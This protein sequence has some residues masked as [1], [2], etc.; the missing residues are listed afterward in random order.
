[1][2]TTP[3][4]ILILSANPTD[5][6]K[7]R[8]DE[9]AREILAGLQRSR[10]RDKFEMI[11]RWAVHP[12]DLRRALLDHSPQIVHFSGHG[13]GSLGLALENHT[14]QTQLV[15]TESL[16]RLFK[17]FKDKVEC[18]LLNACY[19]QEQ[20]EAIYQHI[21][22]V[23]GMNQAIGDRTAIEFAVGFYD[24]LGADRSYEEAYEFGCSAIDLEGIN[25]S[26]IPVLKSRL[27]ELNSRQQGQ[28][29][30]SRAIDKNR[31]VVLENPS[32]QVPLD[33]SFYIE[34]PPIEA[35]CYEIILSEGALIR[36]K[37]PKQMG[38][39]SLMTRIL[40]YAKR[41]GYQ[42]ANLNFQ[43]VDAELLTNLDLFLQWFCAS[44]SDELKKPDKLGDYWKG[45][46]GSKNKCT[47]Y[48]GRY[49][50]PEMNNSI[51]LALDEVDEIF[52]HPTI[53]ADFFGLLRTWHE[54]SKND[55]A[56]RQL[57]LVIVHSQ[58][59]YIPLKINQSPFNVGFA[60]ELPELNFAQVHSLAQRHG[61]HWS[62]EQISELMNLLSGNPYL[63][64][65]AM[66]QI[67]RK[68]MT[69]S[70]LKQ[71]AP[72][73]SGPYSDHLRRHLRNLEDDSQLL[74][75]VKIVMTADAPV[76]LASVEAF[77]LRSMG[78]IKFQGN[79]IKP[80]CDLYRLYFRESLKIN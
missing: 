42:T 73:E 79:Q 9:E 2:N 52:K 21:D 7:L 12:D 39:T 48:F 76:N 40:D 18:V 61:L 43:S 19:S 62:D 13:E 32:G 69:L 6:N 8:L 54:R 38:K 41:Q 1:M 68:R 44:V 51:V 26:S 34:R 57:R 28:A 47:N 4:K 30:S 80:T 67:A 49:L 31:G 46:L 45:V 74:A 64:R 35:D 14:G 33:S 25:E 27:N 5:T 71:V 15:S 59:V 20:A 55:E 65:I 24:A 3:K 75:A 10:S 11:T 56:W 29:L 22:C 58:E 50:L 60:I 77:K 72:T 36:I 78:L 53:A 63:L 66:Y 16:A 23:I 37:A 17:L 70:D